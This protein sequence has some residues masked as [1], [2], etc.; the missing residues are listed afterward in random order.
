MQEQISH[1]RGL[2]RTHNRLWATV[3]IVHVHQTYYYQ[4]NERLPGTAA[5]QHLQQ[6]PPQSFVAASP[7]AALPATNVA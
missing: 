7:H 4:V 5:Q 6:L 2:C 1:H 3:Q